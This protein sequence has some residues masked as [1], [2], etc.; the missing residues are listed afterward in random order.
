MSKIE[1]KTDKLKKVRVAMVGAGPMANSIHCP[2]LSSFKDVE[3][4]AICDINTQKLNTTADKF[5]INKRYTD[6][7]KMI[8]EVVPDGV[9][10][11]GQPYYMYDIWV[12]CLEQKFNLYIEKPMGLT[13]HQSEILAYLAEK[14]KCITQ[15]SH[16]RRTCP[17]LVKMKKE[18]LKKGP[19]YQAVC[20]FYKCAISPFTAAQDHM[21]EDCTHSIDTVRWLCGGEVVEIESRCKRIMTPDIN[22]IGATLHFDNGSTGYVINSWAS[23]RRIFRVQMHAPGILVDAD[24]EGKAYLY[25]DNAAT[26]IEYDTKEV[27]GSDKIAFGGYLAK[28]REFI[29][30]IK[31]GKEKTSSPFRDCLKTMKIANKILAK[32]L[33]YHQ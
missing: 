2:S 33:G 11:I 12:W 22:W 16:Q 4:A 18:C 5:G 1:K 19:I 28:N 10:V 27:A 7:E 26:G 21:M 17:L 25:K 3:I 14:N 24:I 32:D 15:V 20:E 9:Y 8:E 31:T 6:Y 13:I 30:S 23:G 29:D